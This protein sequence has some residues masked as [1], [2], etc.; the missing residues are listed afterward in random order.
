VLDV[1]DELADGR[2]VGLEMVAEDLIDADEP[3][4]EGGRGG[5]G[6]G[7]EGGKAAHDGGI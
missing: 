3:V 6:F 1:L 7:G 2:E 4:L 5:V